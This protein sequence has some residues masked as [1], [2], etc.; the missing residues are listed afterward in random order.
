MQSHCVLDEI[1]TMQVTC[2]LDTMTTYVTMQVTCTLDNNRQLCIPL[3]YSTRCL[4]YLDLMPSRQWLDLSIP[5]CLLPAAFDGFPVW[6]TSWHPGGDKARPGPSGRGRWY[7]HICDS[8][9]IHTFRWHLLWYLY[10]SIF[11]FSRK[12]WQCDSI[13]I[14]IPTFRWHLSTLC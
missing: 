12:R 1:P 5:F 9:H 13:P 4:R 11:V 10:L 3:A 6:L 2:T 14:H 8:I 7:I